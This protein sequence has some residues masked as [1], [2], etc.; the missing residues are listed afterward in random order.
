MVAS[1]VLTIMNNVSLHALKSVSCFTAV[2]YYSTSHLC[3]DECFLHDKTLSVFYFLSMIAKPLFF[4]IIGYIDEERKISTQYIFLKIKSIFLI[5][6]FWNLLFLFMDA[7]LFKR[8]YLL[9]NGVLLSIAIIYLCHPILAKVL[10]RPFSAVLAMFFLVILSVSLHLSIA[11][12]DTWYAIH[13]YDYYGVIFSVAYYLFGRVLGSAQGQRLT[14]RVGMLWTARAGLV[15]AAVLFIIYEGLISNHVLIRSWTWYLL[16]P[17][18]ISI[19]CLLIFIIFDN[20]IIHNK[21]IIKT[22]SFISPAMVG[23]YIIHY[24]VFYLFSTAYDINNVTLRFTLLVAVFMA[25]VIVSRLLL[26][27][28]YTSQVISL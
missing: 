28:K 1:H 8:G 2:T 22:V 21:F 18:I 27:N 11:P 6:V 14:K 4:I 20:L 19:F 23:V 25:S 10:Y 3:D 15:P 17:L 16:E 13:F 12:C 26:L 9:Q 5:V 24:S 7:N